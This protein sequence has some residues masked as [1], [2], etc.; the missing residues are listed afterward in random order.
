ANIFLAFHVFFATID[1]ALEVFYST[2]FAVKFPYF[3]GIIDPVLFV[4]GPLLFLYA[5]FLIYPQRTFRWNMI[6]HFVPAILIVLIYIPTIYVQNTETKLLA[7]GI[8]LD[9]STDNN[10]IINFIIRD[11]IWLISCVYEIIYIIVTV[12]LLKKYGRDIKNIYSF[13]DKINLKWL[14]NLATFMGII[15]TISLL[16]GL[17]VYFEF[18]YFETSVPIILLSFSILIYIIG[19]KGLK[20]PLLFSQKE[21]LEF[22][23]QQEQFTLV[24]NTEKYIKSKLPEEKAEE[25][26]NNLLYLMET[27]QLYTNENLKLRDIADDL[28]ISTHHLSQVINEKLDKNFFDFINS[29]RVEAA[30]K[31]LIDSKYQH[32]T[33]LGI[34]FEVGFNSKSSF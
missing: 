2:P 11:I 24:E 3:I 27:K 19:Y 28:S 31:M 29:Y 4:Y 6:L 12:L 32:L 33:I 22:Q 9:A 18:I 7:E 10:L 23:N 21:S 20:Q 34:A 17:L 14:R 16:M 13:I 8:L 15:T 5:Y 1:L 30:R 25:H 26:L